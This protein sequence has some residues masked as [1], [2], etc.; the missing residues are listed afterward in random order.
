MNTEGRD[1]PNE[2]IRGLSFGS[3]AEHYERYRFGYPDELVDAVA[4]YAEAPLRFALEVGAGTGKATRVLAS[5]GIDV[6]ALE[7]DAGIA[8][9]LA[10]AMRGTQVTTVVTTFEDFRVDRRFDV[11]YAAAAWHWTEPGSRWAHA[12]EL[13]APGGVLALF[14][15]PADLK[16][17]ELFTA[18]D[19]IEKRVLPPE[20][21]TVVH[22]WS[23]EEMVAA[24][25]LVNVVQTDLPRVVTMSATDFV[26]RLTT[27]S[28]YLMLSPADRADLL[29]LVRSVLPDHVDI[30]ATLHL[31][32]ARRV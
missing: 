18:V 1:Q 4:H 21:P 15:S 29:H 23:V 5:R 22:P 24:D 6:T 9:V 27:V 28:S 13:L 3:V 31:A 32:T 30:D 19:E 16:D 14:G 2:R 26:G 25:G 8:H 7:P 12:V 11:V 17:P 20:D 10:H